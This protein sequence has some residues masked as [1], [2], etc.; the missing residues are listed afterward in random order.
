MS[1]IKNDFI[2]IKN[3]FRYITNEGFRNGNIVI[4]K[5]GRWGNGEARV[6]F[7]EAKNYQEVLDYF[8]YDKN[9][10][11]NAQNFIVNRIKFMDKLKENSLNFS[12]ALNFSQNDF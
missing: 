6:I 4:D 7:D 1:L 5:F 2:D 11:D 10:K 3:V 12:S 8:S 9:I